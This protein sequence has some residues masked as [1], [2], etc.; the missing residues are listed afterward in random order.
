MDKDR[1]RDRDTYTYRA[2]YIDRDR[3]IDNGI[4]KD[5]DRKSR[6]RDPSP[7]TLSPG[8]PA[9]QGR[10]GR[11]ATFPVARPSGDYNGS[12]RVLRLGA[13]LRLSASQFFASCCAAPYVFLHMPVCTFF[14]ICLLVS[15][16]YGQLFRR[17]WET[18]ARNWVT[19]PLGAQS[20]AL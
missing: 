18:P 19:I 2:I 16:S 12:L 14:H 6:E 3:Y 9:R 8:G 10:T 17:R 4:H 11:E 20:V 5:N 7:D 1:D 15:F 13:S